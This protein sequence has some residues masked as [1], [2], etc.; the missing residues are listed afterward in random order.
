MAVYLSQQYHDRN[1]RENN[2]YHSF[3]LLFIKQGGRNLIPSSR[4]L[5][6]TFIFFFDL[7]ETNKAKLK[8]VLYMLLKKKIIIV[9]KI[10]FICWVKNF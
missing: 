1:Q 10:D 3:I 9:F 2:Y 8:N 6:L 5:I 4:Y 7:K